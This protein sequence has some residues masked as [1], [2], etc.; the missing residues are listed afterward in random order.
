M[1]DKYKIL[2]SVDGPHDNVI[3]VKPP[4]VFDRDD[5]SMF[6][7]CF[8]RALQDLESMKDSLSGVG[9]TPT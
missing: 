5:A 7:E 8:E 2:T 9:K 1:K 3:V 4:M 6:V